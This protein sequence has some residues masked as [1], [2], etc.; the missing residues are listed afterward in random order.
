MVLPQPAPAPIT[1]QSASHINS[2]TGS[3]IPAFAPRA[4]PPQD[5]PVIPSPLIPAYPSSPPTPQRPHTRSRPLPHHRIWPE[6]CLGEVEPLGGSG[7]P[8]QPRIGTHTCEA[9]EG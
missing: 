7:H 1:H 5:G 4:S 9:Y 6:R 8:P 3:S 2:N